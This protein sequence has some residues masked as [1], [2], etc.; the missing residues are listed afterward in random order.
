[1]ITAILLRYAFGWAFPNESS[2]ATRRFMREVLTT[3]ACPK[4][5]LSF[6]V[7]IDAIYVYTAIQDEATFDL[8]AMEHAIA[9]SV[10]SLLETCDTDGQPLQ[11]VEIPNE[12]RHEVVSFGTLHFCFVSLVTNLTSSDHRLRRRSLCSA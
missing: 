4:L 11:A 5:R 6:P 7:R 3:V 1:L 12:T 8:K 9:S 10:S 2:R